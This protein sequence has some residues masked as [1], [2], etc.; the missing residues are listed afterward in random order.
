MPRTS[1]VRAMQPFLVAAALGLA[2]GPL[3]AAQFSQQLIAH[4]DSTYVTLGAFSGHPGVAL[5]AN[6]GGFTPNE[7]VS[8]VLKV[9]T[10]VVSSAATTANANGE[11]PVVT[12]MVPVTAPQGAVT[13]TATGAVSAAVAT[14]AYYVEP[15]NPSITSAADSNTPG[16]VVAI[17]GIGFAPGETVN[18]AFKSVTATATA[19][20]MGAFAATSLT[21]PDVTP[22][23][24]LPTA[25]GAA[26]GATTNTYFYVS[27]FFASAYPSAYY[28]LPKQVLK[29]SGSG[30]KAGETVNI[31]EGMSTTPVAT[32]KA[33]TAGSFALA[34]GVTIPSTWAGTSR[35]FHIVGASSHGSTDASVTVGQYFPNVYPS[36]YY[37]MPGGSLGFSGSGFVAGETVSVFTGLDTTATTSFV[38]D[39]DGAFLNAGTVPVPMN[40]GGKTL[41][42]RLVGDQSAA[43]TIVSITVG[44]LYPQLSPSDYYLKPNQTFTASGSGFAANEDVDLLIGTTHYTATADKKGV[45]AFTGLV[46]P[47]S[48]L[49]SLTFTAT[50]ATSKAVATVD[51]SVGAYFPFAGADQYYVLPGSTVN[52]TGSGFAPGESVTVALGKV[53]TTV[54]AD[55]NG[56][57]A[58]A[59]LVVPFGLLDSTVTLEGATSGAKA[60]VALTVAPFNPQISLDIYYAQP[61]T[62]VTATGTGFVPGETVTATLGSISTT[63]VATKLGAVTAALKIPFGLIDG[64]VTLT[65]VKSAAAAKTSLTIAPFNAQ[66]SLDTYYTQP[67][68]VV[69]VT[70]AGFVPGETVTAKLGTET[71]TGVADTMGNVAAIPLTIPFGLKKAT[72]TLTGSV[73]AATVST[74]VTLA[75]YYPQVSPSTYYGTP[76]SPI[77]FDGTGFAPGETVTVTK[78]TTALT[79]VTASALGAFHLAGQSLPFGTSVSY[80]F[81]G[82]LSGANQTLPI[83]LAGFSAGL[84]LDSY[85]GNGGSAV[86]LT[87]SG[88]AVGETV[89]V[90]F[91]ATA[92]ADQTADAMGGFTIA[93]HVPY[94]APGDL[95]VT[96]T[97]AASGAKATTGFTVASLSSMSLQ[98]ASYAGQA[99]TAVSF[100]GSGFLPSEPVIVTSDRGNVHFS[101]TAD[102]TGSFTAGGLLPAD[103]ASG[104][105][106]FTVTGQHSMSPATIVFYVQ[107]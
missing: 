17:S 7:G 100:I 15:F 35:T 48:K 5:A 31:L 56:D 8:V 76:G 16:S 107:P 106:T 58:P 36:A 34:G 21:I 81:T 98:M 50:G 87:G 59:A 102:A 74:S 49:A 55:K 71:A 38:A 53:T 52:V 91:G 85:Y 39:E 3:P 57:T 43:S 23:V 94:S 42:F 2:V 44:Q 28:V 18:I 40:A 46:M 103:I 93:T 10:T 1:R 80:T 67:G 6:G 88:F 41:A 24:Y 89:H 78:G 64:T 12:L 14:N 79:T 69:N 20:A 19:D 62:V 32:L 60:N 97:G 51:V 26:S 54:L 77:S 95:S 72:V 68:T 104:N 105:L 4:A 84:S 101:F 33:S 65:G 70:G 29:F 92:L 86:T 90:Q 73:S 45:V 22:G 66:I 82:A 25:T 11:F 61:G 9:G 99:G 13:I 27:G 47:Q 63:V 96:A 37:L 75:P 83:T 30:Y